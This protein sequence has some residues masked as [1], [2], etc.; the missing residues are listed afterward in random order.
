MCHGEQMVGSEV[1]VDAL[2]NYL[3][4][5]FAHAFQQADGVVGFSLAITGA[6]RFVKDDN[7]HVLPWMKTER[8]R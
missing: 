5:E 3:F 4:H 7:C 2:G 6:V 8:K 1:D